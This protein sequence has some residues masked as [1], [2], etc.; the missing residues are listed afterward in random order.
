MTARFSTRS[1]DAD[2]FD[3]VPAHTPEWSHP[4]PADPGT[5]DT[6]P[7]SDPEWRYVNVRRFAE[8]D[9]IAF[10][11]PAADDGLF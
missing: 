11:A 10:A 8:D 3:F 7:V 1:T 4:T 2:S 9:D 6:T 5:A